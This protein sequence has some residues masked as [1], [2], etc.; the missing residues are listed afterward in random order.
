ML[1]DSFGDKKLAF[2]P[3]RKPKDMSETII[4]VV[5]GENREDSSGRRRRRRRWTAQR[6]EVAG[7][8]RRRGRGL[9]ATYVIR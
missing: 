3:G 8:G 4:A 5:E 7:D 6:L 1:E 9:I 2:V